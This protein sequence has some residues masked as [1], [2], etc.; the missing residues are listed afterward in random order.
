MLI[1]NILLFL[2]H[3]LK[4]RE[5]IVTAVLMAF[6]TSLPE[7]FIGIT[8]ALRGVS[9]LSFGTIIGSN[10]IA[11]TIVVGIGAF[12]SKG[13]KFP[14][15][16]LQRSA[17]DASIITLWPLLLILDK[18]LSRADGIILLLVL[19]FYFRQLLSQEERFTKVVANSFRKNHKETKLFFKMGL[20]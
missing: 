16:V 3:F 6:A 14:G 13:L 1:N 10:I 9:S 5:F 12:L 18:E 8:S 2:V 11:L 7:I 15:V 4:W 19:L 20:T 17:F